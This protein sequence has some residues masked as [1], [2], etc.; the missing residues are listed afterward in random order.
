MKKEDAVDEARRD[1]QKNRG[2]EMLLVL[3]RYFSL[4]ACRGVDSEFR[5]EGICKV[6]E[7]SCL[8]D[9]L[10]EW[11]E[12]RGW[13]DEVLGRREGKRRVKDLMLKIFMVIA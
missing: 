2:R 3:A 9:G 10:A 8:D 7:F 12:V 6:F 13:E 5:E 1:V 4:D 11:I